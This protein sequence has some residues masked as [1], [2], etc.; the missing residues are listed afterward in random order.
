MSTPTEIEQLINEKTRLEE[1]SRALDDELKQL[2]TRSRI[3]SEKVAI[4]ELKNE[5]DTKRQTISGLA[6]RISSLETRLEQMATGTT[7]KQEEV[8][9]SENAENQEA[10]IETNYAPEEKQDQDADTIRVM[11]LDNEQEINDNSGAE[12]KESQ[13]LFY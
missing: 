6:S 2:E 10:V 3:L 13:E 9:T 8:A 7:A 11:A 12:E 1:E 4:Q 5:N